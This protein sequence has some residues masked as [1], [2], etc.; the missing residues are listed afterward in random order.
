MSQL[1]LGTPQTSPGESSNVTCF[2]E[3][4]T[5]RKVASGVTASSA[6]GQLSGS[7]T[8]LPPAQLGPGPVGPGP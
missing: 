7:P 3:S 1:L 4:P 6:A 5:I 8:S 2:L